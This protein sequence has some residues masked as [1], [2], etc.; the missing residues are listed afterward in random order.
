MYVRTELGDSVAV[1]SALTTRE[2]S[3]GWARVDCFMRFARLAS[4]RA[5]VIGL[6][7]LMGMSACRAAE[8]VAIGHG[9]TCEAAGSANLLLVDSGIAGATGDAPMIAPSASDTDVEAF[10][11]PRPGGTSASAAFAEAAGSA[12][13]SG[14]GGM[15]ASA[16][17]SG[18][19]GPL[20]T[21]RAGRAGSDPCQP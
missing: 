19:T 6:G 10:T 15:E 8:D 7:V 4:P 2:F 13:R 1:R 3:V 16:G 11:A 18:Q 17:A 20:V 5:R 9:S 21:G 12:G 14:A